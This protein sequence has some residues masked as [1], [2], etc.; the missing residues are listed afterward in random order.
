M[1]GR[2]RLVAALGVLSLLAAFG[3][4]GVSLLVAAR[5]SA[6]APQAMETTPASVGLEYREVA[7]G[8]EDGLR[9]SGWWVPGREAERAAVLVHGWGG[10]KSEEHVLKT[11]RIYGEA[12]YAVLL[13][14]LRG[15]GESEGERRTLGYQEVRDVRGALRWLEGRGFEADEVV[16]HGWSMGAATVVRAAPGTGVVAVVEEAGYADLPLLLRTQLPEASGLPRFFN[17]GSFLIAKLFL[18]FDPWA[19]RPKD[20][21]ARLAVEGTPLYVVHS[22]ADETVPFEHASLF[23]EAYPNA[24]YWELGGV[25]HVAAFEEEGYEERLLRF[26][27]GAGT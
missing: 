27:E 13:M 18:D 26:L 2:R 12:G 24:E 23:R 3:Y 15:H 1:K 25:E 6:P 22:T 17:G 8:S 5:L 20:D 4:F 19:V 14:D 9:L 16:L 10:N 21:A 11:A 7:V